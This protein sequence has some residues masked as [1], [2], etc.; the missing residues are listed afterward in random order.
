MD[1]LPPLLSQEEACR[2]LRISRPTLT[3]LRR[4]GR[5]PF[6]RVGSRGVRIP[7]NAVRSFIEDNVETAPDIALAAP[8]HMRDADLRRNADR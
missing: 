3:E 5:I 7:S 1:Q 8:R 2:E 4:T 6:I